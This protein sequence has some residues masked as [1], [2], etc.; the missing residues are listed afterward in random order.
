MEETGSVNQ[1]P[2]VCAT[3][4]GEVSRRTQE[5]A[6][7]LARERGSALIFFFVADTSFAKISNQELNQAL[8]DELARLGRTLL[9]IAQSRAR[10]RGVVADTAIRHGSISGGALK[11]FLREVEA[12]TLVMGASQVHSGHQS[13]GPGKVDQ[14][15]ETIREAT[16][17]EVVVVV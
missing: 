17:I 6:V 16:G 9:S 12:G 15:A 5:R 11:D 2:I 4:G 8:E 3:R 14:F 10:A 1:H 13:F 7:E